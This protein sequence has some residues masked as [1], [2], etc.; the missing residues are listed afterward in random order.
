M[1]TKTVGASD[2]GVDIVSSSSTKPDGLTLLSLSFTRCSTYTEHCVCIS[3]KCLWVT[4]THTQCGHIFYLFP[5]DER[6]NMCR[7]QKAWHGIKVQK[8]PQFRDLP[9]WRMSWSGSAGHSWN[10]QCYPSVIQ[11]PCRNR[12]T[13][14]KNFC[15]NCLRCPFAM[16]YVYGNTK[17]RYKYCWNHKFY[18]SARLH[19]CS[20]SPSFLEPVKI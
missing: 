15:W 1:M 9:L 18:L 17:Q 16:S 3:A 4:H 7:I 13:N 5:S 10:R 6:V 20:A 19:L 12:N 8:L 14:T 2:A 11:H